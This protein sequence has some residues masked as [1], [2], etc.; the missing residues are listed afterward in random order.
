MIRFD[1]QVGKHGFYTSRYVEAPDTAVAETIALDLIRAELNG[2]VLNDRSD[3]PVMFVKEI[4]ET[5]AFGNRLVPGR[6]FTWFE[7]ET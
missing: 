2:I 5:E 4:E 7:E 1:D 6:G 3:P